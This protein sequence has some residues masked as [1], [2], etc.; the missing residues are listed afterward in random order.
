MLC[1][2]PFLL[3]RRVPHAPIPDADKIAK[4]VGLVYK[5]SMYIQMV[6]LVVETLNQA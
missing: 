3:V 6:T 5:L 1:G 2:T 4:S